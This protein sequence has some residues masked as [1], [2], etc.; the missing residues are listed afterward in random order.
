[1][2]NIC[3][4]N[5]SSEVEDYTVKKLLFHSFVFSLHFP[6]LRAIRITFSILSEIVYELI[7]IYMYS[8]LL[9][10]C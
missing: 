6:S 10:K 1:M 5:Q 8:F 9:H 4:Q 7:N 3:S 2:D